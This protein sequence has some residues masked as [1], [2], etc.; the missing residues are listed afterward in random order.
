MF[1]EKRSLFLAG[2]ENSSVKFRLNQL[3]RISWIA[4][5]PASRSILQKEMASSPQLIVLGFWRSP[6]GSALECAACLDV[7]AARKLVAAER[8]GPAKES[9]VH[10][11][12]A[13][14]DAEE[15]FLTSGVLT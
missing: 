4:L 7:L 15:V 12:H 6:V 2:L 8:V 9:L 13:Y 3:P 14:A 1:I 11:E 10:R 5:R